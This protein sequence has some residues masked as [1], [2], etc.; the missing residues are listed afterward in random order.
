MINAPGKTATDPAEF[1]RL[2]VLTIQGGGVYGLNMLGQ[3]SAVIDQYKVIPMAYAGTSAGAVV[4]AISW[5]GYSPKQIRDLFVRLAVDGDGSKGGGPG[6]RLPRTVVNLLGPIEVGRDRFEYA[7]FRQLAELGKRTMNWV[8]DTLA[9]DEVASTSQAISR[10]LLPGLV[11]G[12]SLLV[13]SLVL[14]LAALWERRLVSWVC[15]GLGILFAVGSGW[16]LGVWRQFLESAVLR[17]ISG[18]RQVISS[19]LAI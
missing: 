6:A 7:D 18:S 12:T 16:A 2:A 4:A 13:F 11:L 10:R 5:A 8:G 19:R 9:P 14:V 1:D 15:C 3:L 17:V